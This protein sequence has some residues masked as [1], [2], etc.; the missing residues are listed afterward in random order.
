MPGPYLRNASVAAADVL[1]QA[2][3]AERDDCARDDAEPEDPE[4][5][6][7]PCRSRAGTAEPKRV[8][9]ARPPRQRKGD[10]REHS[11]DGNRDGR[12]EKL[13]VLAEPCDVD[14]DRER[15]DGEDAGEERAQRRAAS[16]PATA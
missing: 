9:A 16:A 6:P 8:S 5:P 3:H 14:G 12:V 11:S 7:S 10:E 15:R 13:V 1:Q 2:V 4:H